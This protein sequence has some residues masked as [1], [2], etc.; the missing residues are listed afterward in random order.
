MEKKAVRT[1]KDL[2]VWQKAHE[3]TL[4][5]YQ[6]TQRHFPQTKNS[7]SLAS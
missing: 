7:G 2:V 3:L 6:V 4:V 1:F 5:I